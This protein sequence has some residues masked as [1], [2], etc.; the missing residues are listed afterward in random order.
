[1][2]VDPREHTWIAAQTS[3]EVW[4]AELA[5]SPVVALDTEFVRE[6]TYYPKL[7][8]I[9]I[10]T[11]RAAACVDCL[12]PLDLEP[13]FSVLF[14]PDKTWIVHSARQDL[15]VLWQRTQRLPP[16]LI[17]TQVAAALTGFPPQVGL[18]GL[19]SRTLGV[20][21]GAD[22]ARTDWSRRPLP[23]EVL[24][25]AIDDVRYLLPAWRKLESQLTEL[26]RTSWLVEDS[27]RILAEP[28][29]ADPVAVFS[30]LKG[31][32]ALPFAS[33]CAALALVQ[34]REAAAQRADRPRRWLI[35]DEALLEI[36]ARLPA[37]PDGFDGLLPARFAARHAEEL[38]AVIAARG[39]PAIEAVVRRYAQHQIPDK[40]RVKALQERV[41]QRAA[42]LGIEPEIL[43]TRR[44]LVALAQGSVPAHL[45]SG[46]R[47]G[48]LDGITAE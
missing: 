14:Q 23:P 16:R 38:L 18:D 24:R 28:P 36:A 25:Y 42:E 39:D 19:L 45:E 26:G 31:V 35:A 10:A 4:A 7:C 37:A 44:D 17:D 30:R 12:A 27:E 22:Y 2:T 8:V 29:V 21:L 3:V 40:A 41:R 20:T 9:Q 47:A 1:V 32:F 46:W 11:D 43:A 33:Q 13:L 34:W 48:V 6:K 5:A 15:E